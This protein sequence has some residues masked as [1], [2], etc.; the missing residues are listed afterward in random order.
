MIDS[1]PATTNTPTRLIAQ[2]AEAR[3]ARLWL[4][5]SAQKN[6]EAASCSLMNSFFVL[7]VGTKVG[8]ASRADDV[9]AG[10]ANHKKCVYTA[11]LTGKSTNRKQMG[12]NRAAGQLIGSVQPR[13]TSSRE[14]FWTFY[15]TMAE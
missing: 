11:E 4:A 10:G 2:L 5:G 14:P 6:H 15:A 9:V 12:T 7:R 3:T 1:Q 8:Q 13:F